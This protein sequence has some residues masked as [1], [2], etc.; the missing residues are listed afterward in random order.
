MQVALAEVRARSSER[1]EGKRSFPKHLSLSDNSS[2]SWRTIENR[3]SSKKH[4]KTMEN[5]RENMDF[6]DFLG[7]R[8]T[9]I[10]WKT[11]D[12]ELNSNGPT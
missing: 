4:E 11:N 5:Q 2:A 3:E 9:K 7:F 12:L 1:V 10:E 8:L 6:L